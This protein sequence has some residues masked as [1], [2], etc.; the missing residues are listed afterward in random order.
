MHA[1]VGAVVAHRDEAFIGFVEVDAVRVA[2]EVRTTAARNRRDA[3]RRAARGG[4]P[5]ELV[6]RPEV[7]R[8][9]RGARTLDRHDTLPIGRP[10]GGIVERG[11]G[12]EPLC[13]APAV[14]AGLL[15]RD[16]LVRPPYV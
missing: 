12:R 13:L 10:H 5:V 6:A 14:R 15:D 7:L 8:H 11:P 3:R 2:A 9:T 16:A 1:P 4:E